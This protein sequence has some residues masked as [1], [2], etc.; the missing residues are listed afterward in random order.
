MRARCDLFPPVSLDLSRTGKRSIN[1]TLPSA[2]HCANAFLMPSA[3]FAVEM[4]MGV[5]GREEVEGGRAAGYKG[6][7]RL[8]SPAETRCRLSAANIK[9]CKKTLIRRPLHTGFAY[10][11]NS[12]GQSLVFIKGEIL[13]CQADSESARRCGSSLGGAV[14]GKKTKDAP[15]DKHPPIGRPRTPHR[16]PPDPPALPQWLSAC[17]D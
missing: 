17:G 2:L 12:C 8:I 11:I 5:A 14:G 10:S 7:G 3:M 6:A 13:A 9:Y 4:K 15:P 1:H 16:F